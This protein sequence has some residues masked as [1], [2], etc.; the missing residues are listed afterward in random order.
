MHFSKQI[1]NN[2]LKLFLEYVLKN[3]RLE[4]NVLHLIRVEKKFD[5]L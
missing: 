2:F 4:L 5:Q 1:E 3:N